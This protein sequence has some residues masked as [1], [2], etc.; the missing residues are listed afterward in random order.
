MERWV[1]EDDPWTCVQQATHAK[2]SEEQLVAEL[3]A[4]VER[5][6]GQGTD[7]TAKVIMFAVREVAARRQAFD[8]LACYPGQRSMG[9]RRAGRPRKEAVRASAPPATKVQQPSIDVPSGGTALP[10]FTPQPKPTTVATSPA[11][12]PDFTP[13]PQQQPE[14]KPGSE[15][16][17][18]R[19]QAA[20]HVCGKPIT[21]RG[22]TK[23]G[24]S[25]L[26]C[27][28]DECPGAW[29]TG[30]AS[31]LLRTTKAYFCHICGA[32][33]VQSR[34]DNVFR[35]TF[36]VR[37]TPSRCK[38]WRD[39]NGEPLGADDVIRTTLPFFNKKFGL[40]FIYRFGE[41]NP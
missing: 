21:I 38:A 39:L 32:L 15:S 34:N 9:A 13:M 30:S 25:I 29:V 3:K 37:G 5:C 27:D 22:E 12:P 20:C 26:T 6:F 8:V 33:M 2:W 41:D 16:R 35:C 24:W 11:S 14:V 40:R 36:R 10:S 4:K 28:D 18:T 17:E 31:S 23:Q 19:G 1:A 7:L